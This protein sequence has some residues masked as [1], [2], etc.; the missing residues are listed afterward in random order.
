LSLYISACTAGIPDNSCSNDEGSC[1]LNLEDYIM[2]DSETEES[3]ITCQNLFEQILF[4]NPGAKYLS[5][6]EI[7]EEVFHQFM[8]S[9]QNEKKCEEYSFEKYTLT[10]I[11]INPGENNKIKS[12]LTFDIDIEKSPKNIWMM[13]YQNNL[14]D[15]TVKNRKIEMEIEKDGT[16]Y[17]LIKINYNI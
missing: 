8:K 11:K 5:D 9:V 12:V 13:K 10:D 14:K 4:E 16:D 17:K 6:Y 7:S 2:D 3:G 15:N 1:E